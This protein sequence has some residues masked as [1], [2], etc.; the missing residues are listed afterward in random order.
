MSCLTLQLPGASELP[1]LAAEA[2]MWAQACFAAEAQ[3]WMHAHLAVDTHSWA[4]FPAMQ[5]S[6]ADPVQPAPPAADCLSD[7][8]SLQSHVSRCGN[9]LLGK[10][11]L[12]D[13]F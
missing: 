5:R 1:H 13:D 4:P 6:L 10:P 3:V 8:A 7:Q 9:L 2:Q 11:Q 12:T